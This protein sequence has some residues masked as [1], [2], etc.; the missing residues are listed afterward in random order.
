MR[1]TSVSRTRLSPAVHPL[2]HILLI[3]PYVRSTKHPPTTLLPLRRLALH[4]LRHL[5]VDV[6]ELGD[7]AVQADGLALVQVGLAVIRRDA[8]L[9]ARLD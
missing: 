6:E 9:R 2:P 8:L 1:L 3:P 7:T 4:L 5:D